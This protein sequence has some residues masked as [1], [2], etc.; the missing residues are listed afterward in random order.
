MLAVTIFKNHEVSKRVM[1]LYLYIRCE[2]LKGCNRLRLLS[3]LLNTTATS[4]ET[5]STITFQ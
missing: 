2:E 3:S 5:G 1:L 4:N